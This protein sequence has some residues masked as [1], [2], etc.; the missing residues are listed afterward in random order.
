[1][2][3]MEPMAPCPHHRRAV[4]LIVKHLD[5]QALEGVQSPAPG[6]FVHLTVLTLFTLSDE[7]IRI[8]DCCF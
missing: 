1:M 4:F 6:D 2:K 7:F 3:G 5:H 8:S